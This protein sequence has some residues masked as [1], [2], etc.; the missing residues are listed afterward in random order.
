MK[1]DADLFRKLLLVIEEL[2]ANQ[3]SMAKPII[4]D[5]QKKNDVY[6]KNTIIEHFRICIDEGFIRGNYFKN[7]AGSVSITTLN[8]L[9]YSGHQLLAKIR[10][11]DV[12]SKLKKSFNKVGSNVSLKMIDTASEDLIQKLLVGS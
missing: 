8:G 7:A 10:E 9:E 4:T 2:P 3:T 1:I 6:N 12:W 5:F 11:D